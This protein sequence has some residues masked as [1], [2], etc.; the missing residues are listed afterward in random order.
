LA[1]YKN[2]TLKGFGFAEF[3]EESE[4]QEACGKHHVIRNK[5]V[6]KSDDLVRNQNFG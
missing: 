5:Q 1:F 2:G 3:M 6:S 4:A